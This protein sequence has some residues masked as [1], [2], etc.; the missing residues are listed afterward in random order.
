MVAN[1]GIERKIVKIQLVVIIPKKKKNSSLAF[2][3]EI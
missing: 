2:E 3:F 1:V